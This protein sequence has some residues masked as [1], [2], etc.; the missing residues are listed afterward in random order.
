MILLKTLV[1][2]PLGAIII[3]PLF[4]LVRG[5]VKA[6]IRYNG[7]GTGTVEIVDAGGDIIDILP[8]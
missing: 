4:R 8:I 7:D 2:E 5:T 1:L 3:T 6:I